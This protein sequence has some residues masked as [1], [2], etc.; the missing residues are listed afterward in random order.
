MNKRSI[1]KKT[2]SFAKDKLSKDCT[3]GHDWWHIERVWNNAKAI[4]KK[5]G[6]DQFI[7]DLAVLLHDV[8]DWKVIGAKE[9]DYTIAENFLV[10]NK[11]K[12]DVIEKV[13]F[14][15]KNMSFSST[16][17][18]KTKETSKEFKVVQDADR[19]DALGAVGI[20]RMFAYGGS[21]QRSIYDPSEK[22]QKIKSKTAYKEINSSTFRHFYD[23]VLFLKDL[24]NTKTAR[25]IAGKRHK[26]VESYIKQFL[27]EWG[28]EK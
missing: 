19:L 27:S 11:V 4:N 13:M 3:G 6:A 17:D 9:D 2:I 7:I 10:K 28:G 5:E 23:K 26:Y 21:R 8:G 18:K 1:I 22:I 25:A 20:A 12:E 24:M 15:I 16:F 14:I